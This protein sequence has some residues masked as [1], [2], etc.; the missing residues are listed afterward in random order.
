M[1]QV[2]ELYGID[3]K[4]GMINCIFHDDRNPSMKL[5]DDHYHCFSCGAHGDAVAFAAKI[6]GV[7]QYEAAKQ[8][9]T[10]FGVVHDSKEPFIKKT[11]PQE[12]RLEME[13]NAFRLLSD[14]CKLLREWRDKYCPLDSDSERHTL[15][16]ESILNLETYEYYC[17]IFIS[18]T[19]EERERFLTERGDIL[20]DIR[21]RM[22]EAKAA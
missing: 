6:T 18:G 20:A 4:S 15:F 14:Y 9:C 5:Y 1:Q 13:T 22:A 8:L 10:A 19:R 21:Q 12:S 3:T 16:N 17:D 2:V 11:V 7:S